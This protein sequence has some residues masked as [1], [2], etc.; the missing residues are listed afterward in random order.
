[1]II[2]AHHLIIRMGVINMM[3]VFYAV[4]IVQAQKKSGK[5][6]SDK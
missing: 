6:E 4:I 5:Y 1:M 3:I 2:I